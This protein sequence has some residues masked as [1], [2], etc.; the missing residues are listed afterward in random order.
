MR[1]MKVSALPILLLCASIAAAQTKP[2][3]ESIPPDAPA[4]VRA[5]LEGCFAPSALARGDAAKKLGELG[6]AA[7]A[8]VP[9][10][11]SMLGDEESYMDSIKI[12]TM[13]IHGFSN[14]AR[15]AALALG[16]IGGPALER[17]LR[18]VQ[19]KAGAHRDMAAL[20]LGRAK[21][22]R[23]VAP[24]IAALT[25]AD[26]KLRAEAASALGSLGD[27]SAVPPLISALGDADKKVSDNAHQALQSLTEQ[28]FGKDPA[29]WQAWWKARGGGR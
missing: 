25:D 26:A 14:P 19:N 11:F 27:K 24:L 8:A 17:L 5:I 7:A 3:K 1:T 6:P 12:D 28:S 15:Q 13:V 2:T 4:S 23:A 21:D 18:T 20:A 9:I 16:A 22:P 10:L 29:Q